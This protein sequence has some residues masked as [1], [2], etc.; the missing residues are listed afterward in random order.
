LAPA[1]QPHLQPRHGAT[2]IG[3]PPPIAEGITRTSTGTFEL[4]GIVRR[5]PFEPWLDALCA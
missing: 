1:A 5:P 4:G 2:A 3:G